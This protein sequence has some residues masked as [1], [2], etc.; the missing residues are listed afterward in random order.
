MGDSPGAMKTSPESILIAPQ[1]QCGF[2]PPSL[3]CHIAR[4]RDNHSMGYADSG[5]DD[6][7]EIHMT[8]MTG[9]GVAPEASSWHSH[10]L[11]ARHPPPAG[12]DTPPTT[13]DVS[14]LQGAPNLAST[15]NPISTPI[16]CGRTNAP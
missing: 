11:R 15:R 16:G 14:R 4:T 13:N 7:H 1:N 9:E 10:H 6:Q 12:P 2:R 8:D 3:P 5:P